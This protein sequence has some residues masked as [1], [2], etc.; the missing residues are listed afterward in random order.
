MNGKRV[1]ELLDRGFSLHTGVLGFWWIMDP[2]TSRC[3]NVSRGVARSLVRKGLIRHAGADQWVR[4]RTEVELRKEILDR[5]S[6]FYLQT[7]GSMRFP[8]SAEGDTLKL[9]HKYFE[10]SKKSV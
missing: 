1:L 10:K 6:Y 8:S 2:F 3:I 5:M 7:D 9:V 4:E